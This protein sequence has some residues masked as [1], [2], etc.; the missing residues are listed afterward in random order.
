MLRGTWGDSWEWFFAVLGVGVY[1]LC[2]SL[3]THFIL[4]LSFLCQTKKEN[5]TQDIYYL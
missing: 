2:V 3:P 5:E 4:L 1:D